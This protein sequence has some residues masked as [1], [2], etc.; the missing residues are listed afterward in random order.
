MKAAVKGRTRTKRFFGGVVPAAEGP[1]A[2][3]ID[4]QSPYQHYIF[5]VRGGK[6][7]D[8]NLEP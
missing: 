3:R 6:G 5:L 4:Y 8:I 2:A 1:A 7:G